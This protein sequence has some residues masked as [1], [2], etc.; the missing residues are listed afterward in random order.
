MIVAAV[1]D[2]PNL[3]SAPQRVDQ[4]LPWHGPSPAAAGRTKRLGGAPWVVGTGQLQSSYA[5]TP[6]DKAPVS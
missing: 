1:Y 6:V 4:P 3:R 2:R 5:G